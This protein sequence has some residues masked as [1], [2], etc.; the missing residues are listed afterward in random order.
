ML[1]L[2]RT[3]LSAL[4]CF[5]LSLGPVQAAGAPALWVVQGAKAKV[6]LF[7]TIHVLKPGVDWVTPAIDSALAASDDLWL[8]VPENLNDVSAILPQ[9]QNSG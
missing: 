7:G 4:I 9:V 5:A 6:Y 1:P 2:F 3:A 8:E